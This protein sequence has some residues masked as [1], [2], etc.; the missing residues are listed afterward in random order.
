[1]TNK[2]YQNFP[3]CSVIVL[4]YNGKN[5]LKRCLNSL[6]KQNYQ[7]YEI[8]LVDNASTD[9]SVNFVK[10][11]YPRIRIIENKK[12]LGYAEGNNTGIRVANG[13]YIVI[14]NNDTEV[15]NEWLRELTVK[16]RDEEKVGVVG[17]KIYWMNE[18]NKIQSIGGK[19]H[20]WNNFLFFGT[21]LGA[22]EIDVGQYEEQRE[23][24]YAM[25]CAFLIKKKVLDKIG[26]FDSEYFIY[27]EEIDLQYQVKKIGY[28]MFF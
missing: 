11:N 23:I 6:L 5:H 13:E 4:N 25:G 28:K 18:P 9:G 1:M 20:I 21:R 16:A 17:G 8:I 12:N 14:L 27:N 2:I 3:M 10:K 7:N 24:D 19:L 15:D 22:N 26:L